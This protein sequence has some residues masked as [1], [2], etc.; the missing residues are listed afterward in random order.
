MSWRLR[1]RHVTG[2]SYPDSAYASYNEARMT[3]MTVPWQITLHSHLEVQPPVA[4][5]RYTDYWGTAVTA[6]DLQRGHQRMAVTATS[7]V[8]TGDHEPP[9]A[10]LSWPALRSAEQR[11][12]YAELLTPTPL[13]R[14][15]ADLVGEA[16]AVVDG[17]EPAEAAVALRSEEHTSELQSH[18]DLV[19][20]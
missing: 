1:I 14:V 20:R 12:R 8:E 17:A 9:T 7:L 4:V 18:H 2:F 10:T 16:A 13:T 3:P 11:D 6:F 5:W 15:S 19:C